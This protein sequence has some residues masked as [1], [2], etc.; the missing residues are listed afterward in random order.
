MG[1]RGGEAM[2]GGV[3][4]RG[5]SIRRRVVVVGS[6]NLDALQGTREIAP[7]GKTRVHCVVQ[8]YTAG[9]KG[10]GAHQRHV[11]QLHQIS[12]KSRS[13]LDG[14]AHAQFFCRAGVCQGVQIAERERER[15]GECG[16]D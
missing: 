14:S 1:G 10:V 6:W 5:G 15:R 12:V 13:T 3:G 9:R 16:A 7:Q 2:Q 8:A 11:E 4:G